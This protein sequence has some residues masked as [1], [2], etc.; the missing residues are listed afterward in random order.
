MAQVLLHPRQHFKTDGI[1]IRFVRKLPKEKNAKNRDFIKFNPGGN[2][3]GYNVQKCCFC[4]K[5]KYSP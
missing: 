3:L 5:K 4:D 1:F 2:I